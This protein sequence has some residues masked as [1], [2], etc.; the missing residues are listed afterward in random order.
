MEA[1]QTSKKMSRCKAAIIYNVPESTLCDWINGQPSCS[2]TQAN[3]L[4]LTKLEEGVIVNYILD[5]DSRGFSPRQADVEDIAN[6][7]QKCW[8][9]KPVG[10]L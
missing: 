4:N 1:I 7:L 2:D 3:S 5:W 6:Y 9:V 8:R 10:K